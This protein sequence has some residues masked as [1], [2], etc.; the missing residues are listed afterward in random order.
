MFFNINE[1]DVILLE[2]EFDKDA[3]ILVDSWTIRQTHKS[4]FLSS[5]IG[6]KSLPFIQIKNQGVLMYDGKNKLEFIK[7]KDFQL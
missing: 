7:D 2:L 1:P 3:E 6:E 5:L 4:W